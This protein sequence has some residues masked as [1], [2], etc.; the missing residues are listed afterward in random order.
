MDRQKDRLTAVRERTEWGAG[1]YNVPYA[2]LQ[3]PNNEKKDGKYRN[4]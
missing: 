2:Y 1:N 4:V 3:L